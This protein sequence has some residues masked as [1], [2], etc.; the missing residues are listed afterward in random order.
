VKWNGYSFFFTLPSMSPPFST[1]RLWVPSSPP[2]LEVPTAMASSR[3]PSL[4]IFSLSAAARAW[5]SRACPP[6]PCSVR[7]SSFYPACSIRNGHGLLGCHHPATRHGTCVVFPRGSLAQPVSFFLYFFPRQQTGFNPRRRTK[8]PSSLSTLLFLSSP[9]GW[10]R[11]PPRGHLPWLPTWRFCSS[12]AEV[13]IQT[14]RF[15]PP[16]LSS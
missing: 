16:P 3:E 11:R 9:I 14:K 12:T 7:R 5:H 4:N 13:V 15:E 2:F 10:R 6:S 8:S 1:L